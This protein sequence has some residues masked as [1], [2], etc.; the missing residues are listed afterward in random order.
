[1]SKKQITTDSQ[2]LAAAEDLALMINQFM[3]ERNMNI[4]SG[5]TVMSAAAVAV[6]ESVCKAVGEDPKEGL[7]AYIDG[8]QAWTDEE[9]TAEGL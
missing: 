5:L 2:E 8:L 3:L 4:A 1:M 9:T 6:I 7:Q